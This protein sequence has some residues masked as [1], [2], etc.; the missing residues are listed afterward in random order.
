[1]EN[2]KCDVMRVECVEFKVY[3]AECKVSQSAKHATGNETTRC[4]IIPHK[5]G[6]FTLATV[7]H[8]FLLTRRKSQ[9][10]TLATPN[11]AARLVSRKGNLQ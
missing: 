5:L 8:T 10:A 3:S 6:N 7:A 9:S 1:M 2:V 4:L 11:D